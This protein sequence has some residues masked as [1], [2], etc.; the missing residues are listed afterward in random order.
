MYYSL[1]KPGFGKSSLGTIFLISVTDG[2]W[3]YF[4]P[5]LYSAIMH[6]QNGRRSDDIVHPSELWPLMYCAYGD[7][8]KVCFDDWYFTT[9]DNTTDDPPDFNADEWSRT[10]GTSP[11]HFPLA[12]DVE[13]N[14]TPSGTPLC[15]G[16]CWLQTSSSASC[17]RSDYGFVSSSR[18]SSQLL[19]LPYSSLL[20]NATSF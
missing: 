7:W 4:I 3:L 2:I 1:V 16:D 5:I 12:T 6:H 20:S 15:E 14:V 17:F 10:I 8:P 13:E 11:H 9:I 19:S 18:F